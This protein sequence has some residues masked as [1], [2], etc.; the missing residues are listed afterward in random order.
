MREGKRW[1]GYDERV[2]QPVA[3]GIPER[4]PASKVSAGSTPGAWMENQVKVWVDVSGGGGPL[5]PSTQLWMQKSGRMEQGLKVLYMR[6]GIK[7]GDRERR[8]VLRASVSPWTEEAGVLARSQTLPLRLRNI[9][10]L[11]Q[12]GKVPLSPGCDSLSM[13]WHFSVMA[14]YVRWVC[15]GEG[16]RGEVAL[17]GPLTSQAFEPLEASAGKW[18]PAVQ[19]TTTKCE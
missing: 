19:M 18:R 6:R 17:W 11:T 3:S 13:A 14:K 12:S 2:S 16:G 4:P 7:L 10:Y 15:H 1:T 5:G 8:K 9:L